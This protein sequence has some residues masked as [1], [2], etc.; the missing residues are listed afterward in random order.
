MVLKQ[1]MPPYEEILKTY[2]SAVKA[3]KRQDAH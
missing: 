2:F 3:I 1:V